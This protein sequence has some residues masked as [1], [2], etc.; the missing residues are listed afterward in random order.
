MEVTMSTNDVNNFSVSE[1]NYIRETIEGMNKFNQIEVLRLLSKHKDITL[2]ENKYG[3][4]VNLSDIK[5]EFLEE[6]SVYINY[7][8]SQEVSL[9]KI[10]QQKEEYKNTF[11]TKDIKDNM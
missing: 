8:N 7:V 5:R 9:H 4:L 11:F 6:L 1:L 2:N 3:V 10:E